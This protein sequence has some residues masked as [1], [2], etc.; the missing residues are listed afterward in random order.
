MASTRLQEVIEAVLRAFY[1]NIGTPAPA[2]GIERLA[3]ITVETAKPLMRQEWEEVLLS[4]VV[5]EAVEKAMASEKDQS[6]TSILHAA[7]SA[8]RKNEDGI[9]SG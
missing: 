1:R 3:A 8:M 7:A 2:P 9:G 5:T 4:E 6:I